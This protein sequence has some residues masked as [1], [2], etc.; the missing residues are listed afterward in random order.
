MK[1]FF[2]IVI[3][4]LLLLAMAGGPARVHAEEADAPIKI[5]LYPS[6]EPQPALKYKLLP[7]RAEQIAGNAAVYYGKVKA[8][9][10]V[11][12]GNR[13]LRENI[14][15]WQEIPLEEL[16]AEE[17]R[18]PIEDIYF[19]LDRGARCRFCDWQM[20]IGDVQFYSTLLPEIQESR[21]FSRI[22]AASARIDI[23]HRRYEKAL[24]RFQTNYALGRHIAESEF[25]VGGLVGAAICGNMTAQVTE[26]VQQP[27]TPNLY[28]ALATLPSPLIDMREA[29]ELESHGLDLSY[30]ELAN[31]EGVG[32]RAF[33]QRE[34]IHP[35]LWK[36]PPS[37]R[38]PQQ[39]KRL[40]HAIITD[41]HTAIAGADSEALK[42]AE[43]LEQ[44]CQDAYPFVKRFLN[45]SSIDAKKVEAMSVH[46]AALV[47][48]L[49]SFRDQVDDMSKYYGLPYPVAITGLNAVAKHYQDVTKNVPVEF[50]VAD[51][52]VPAIKVAKEAETRMD[53]EIAVLRIFEA[54][55]IHGASRSGK[56][57]EH[58]SD[59]TEVPIPLDPVTGKPFVYR[60]EVNTATLRGPKLR[61]R[62]LNYEIEM[63]KP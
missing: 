33:S 56:L 63:M 23:A 9:Q 4:C 12:F 47:Y 5:K 27:D 16:I 19:Q 6:A 60:L 32:L 26:F 43:V 20:P 57:P 25:I 44:S 17:V 54:L 46:Q 50:K 36:V 2:S 45:N 3:S 40:Y 61:N 30:P 11:F 59:I 48:M 42:S 13:E 15:R 39:W 31:Y 22:L 41:V 35:E 7:S 21:Q 29:I 14:D 52:L 18:L 24:R 51:H 38:T 58:L 49:R 8:E 10:N 34:Q 62:A 28:W 37:R 1:R 53:R 55:R